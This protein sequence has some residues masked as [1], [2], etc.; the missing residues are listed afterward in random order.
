MDDHVITDIAALEALYGQPGKASLIKVAD[1]VT[2]LYAK[3]IM[4]SRLCMVSTVGPEGTDGSPRGDDG[5]VV[6]MLD[7]KTL[8]MPDWRGNNRMDTL[9]NI[10]ADGRV[11]L[12]FIIPGSNNV[13]RVNGTAIVS[14]APDLLA[15]FDQ[16]GRQPRS[17]VV[18]TVAE[19]YSQCARALMRARV[20]SSGDESAGLP[21]VG[22]L[23]AEQEEGFDGAAYDAEWPERAAKTM[24]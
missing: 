20:W 1:H 8:L 10:V 6:Q 12:M 16:K 18:I 22:E 2:P 9:R 19:V 5:P 23:L 24:W 11:S 15:R 14:T 13:M 21:T 4:A 7:P 17:V 3:W